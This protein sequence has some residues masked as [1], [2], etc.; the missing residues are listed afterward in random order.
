MDLHRDMTEVE[1][2]SSNSGMGDEIFSHV[3]NFEDSVQEGLSNVFA[4][5][6]QDTLKV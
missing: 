6:Q 3:G 1:V 2:K 5:L 4:S